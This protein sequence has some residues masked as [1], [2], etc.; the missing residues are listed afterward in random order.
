MKLWN[1]GEVVA[2]REVLRNKVYSAVA[3]RVVEDTENF[4]V[5]YIS[6]QTCVHWPHTLN[7]GGIRIPP[8]EWILV[9]DPWP[10]SDTLYLIQPGAGYTVI[11]FWNSMTFD[12]WKI[13]L[14][15]PMRRTELGFDYMD[16]LLDIIVDPDRSTWKWKDEDEIQEAQARGMFTAEQVRD[17]YQRGEYAVQLL[18]SRTPPFDRE[19]ENWKP[20]LSWRAPLHLPEGWERV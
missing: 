18:Q 8:A 5:L 12:H 16:Q 11:A 13:N 2:V 4:S 9:E 10:F 15:E 7:G 1:S 3:M 6:P 20:E 17:L 14:E 19:W